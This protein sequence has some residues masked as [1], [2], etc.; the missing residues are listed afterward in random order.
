MNHKLIVEEIAGRT[1]CAKKDLPDLI[2]HELRHTGLNSEDMKKC[3]EEIDVLMTKE[4]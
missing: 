1:F 2:I 4:N 3:K